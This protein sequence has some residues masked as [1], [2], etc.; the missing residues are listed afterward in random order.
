MRD[1]LVGCLIN[2]FQ[3]GQYWEE[4]T[5]VPNDAQKQGSSLTPSHSFTTKNRHEALASIETHD[6]QDQQIFWKKPHW[7]PAVDNIKRNTGAHNRWLPVKK[8]WHSP[9]SAQQGVFEKVAAC[10]E[11]RPVTFLKGC[12]RSS[13]VQTT[14]PFSSFMWAQTMQVGRT[15]A[16]SKTIK[17]WEHNW[18]TSGRPVD[19]EY[20]DFS[21]S[22]DTLP[23]HPCN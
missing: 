7:H 2:M 6:T 22:C 13:K 15:W 20:L 5:L 12:H 9:L 4:G 17:P 8:H 1:R 10:Q 14:I 11:P 16:E 3:W 21:K 19:A 18:K 23:Q